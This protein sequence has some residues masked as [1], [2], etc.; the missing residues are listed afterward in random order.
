M[1][2]VENLQMYLGRFGIPYQRAAIGKGKAP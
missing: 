2:L 1:T